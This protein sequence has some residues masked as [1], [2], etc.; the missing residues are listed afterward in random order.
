MSGAGRKSARPYRWPE[1]LL[2]DVLAGRVCDEVARFLDVRIPRRYE[3]WLLCKAERCFQGDERFRRGIRAGGN[4]G[5][6]RLLMF[7][8]HWMSS[9]LQCERPDLWQC[10]PPDFD[11]GLPL[12][13]AVQ[14]RENRRGRGPIPRPRRWNPALVP[15]HSRWRF[16]AAA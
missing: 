2:P 9:L 14:P 6:D 13:A 1:A 8:R 11:V 15:A 16:L 10:L 12:P 5:R 3:A 7:M 4:R